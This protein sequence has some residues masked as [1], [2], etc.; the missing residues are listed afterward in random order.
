MLKV[1]DGDTTIKSEEDM[2]PQCE[3]GDINGDQF[4]VN[5]A[6]A[7]QDCMCNVCGCEWTLCF[8][9]ATIIITG[10]GDKTDVEKP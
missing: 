4:D 1:K 2:C 8:N 6:V 5:D 9:L 3:S 10:D 7:E